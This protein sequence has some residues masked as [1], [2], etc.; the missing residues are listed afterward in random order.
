MVDVPSTD[1][2][3]SVTTKLSAFEFNQYANYWAAAAV[4]LR[5]FSSNNNLLGETRIVYKSPHYPWSNSNT[6]H[7]ISVS[8]SSNWHT[9]SFNLNDELTNLSGINTANIKKI[10][11][12]LMDTTNGC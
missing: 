7:L 8:D 4:C 6:V 10:Q 2:Q 9:Y 1:I 12:V 3:F 5:Y 11:I